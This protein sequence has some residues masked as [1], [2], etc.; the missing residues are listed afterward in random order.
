MENGHI[1]F[2]SSKD[3][4]NL[5]GKYKTRLGKD[6]VGTLNINFWR[7]LVSEDGQ[8]T[9]ITHIMCMNPNGKM[10]DFAVGKMT[11]AQ[12]KG[13]LNVIDLVKSKWFVSDYKLNL[14]EISKFNKSFFLL[15]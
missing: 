11:S 14:E 13:A 9:D 8:G 3:T 4:V 5:V 1:F 12:A 15:R 7:F 6:V 2:L 10:P